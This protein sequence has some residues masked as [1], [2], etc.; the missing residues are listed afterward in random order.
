MTFDG[1]GNVSFNYSGSLNGTVFTGQSTSGAYS[2][3][4]DCTASLVFTSGDGAG[5]TAN[6]VLLE[7]GKEVLG[8]DTGAGDTMT[9][10]LKKQRDRD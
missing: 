4:S 3:N 5:F 6:M 8:V 9:F 10:D 1:E 7:D 2:V